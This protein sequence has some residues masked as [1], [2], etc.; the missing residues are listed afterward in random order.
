MNAQRDFNSKML[1]R[2]VFCAVVLLMDVI[3]RGQT[4]EVDEIRAHADK[5][6]AE[7]Q[8]TLGL[9]YKNGHGVAQDSAQALTWFQKAAEQG[10]AAA[11]RN[12]G[13]MYAEGKGAK[14][15][16]NEAVKWLRKAA[17]SITLISPRGVDAV[18]PFDVACRS[19]TP[20]KADRKIWWS[21]GFSA[22][23]TTPAMLLAVFACC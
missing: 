16:F 9:A 5:G 14:Q 20:L 10:N 7:A 22:T 17:G 23:S 8:N 4:P 18:M 3:S 12:L 1:F 6:E 11:Q 13:L 19:R 15:D 21:L 2:L